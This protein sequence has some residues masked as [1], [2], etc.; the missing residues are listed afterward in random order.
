MANSRF[1]W[2]N[3]AIVAVVGCFVLA[4]LWGSRAISMTVTPLVL[5]ME[6]V[7]SQSKAS[8]RIVNDSASPLPV[9]IKVSRLELDD[10]GESKTTPTGEDFLIFPPQAIIPAGGSQAIRVQWIGHGEMEKSQSFIFAVNQLPVKFPNE[11]SGVQ[12]VFNFAVVVNV[13]PSASTSAVSLKNVGVTI[14]DY[15]VKHP[16]IVVANSGNRHANIG[17]ATL[18]L[19][20]ESWSQT[21]SSATLSQILGMGLVQPGRQRRFVLTTTTLPPQVTKLRGHLDYQLQAHATE[22]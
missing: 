6:N 22:Q 1:S 18:V 13:A 17:N 5:E 2:N 4:F 8:L 3:F 7:G 11:K 20:A 16:V 12:I 10:S 19:S 15:G 14:D 9:E 21:I